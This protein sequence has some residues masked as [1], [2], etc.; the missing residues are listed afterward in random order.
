MFVHSH[1]PLPEF[2]CG[3]FPYKSSSITKLP[4]KNYFENYLKI[5]RGNFSVDPCKNRSRK[6]TWF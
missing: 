5:V 4:L 1:A 2:L 6:V 3:P